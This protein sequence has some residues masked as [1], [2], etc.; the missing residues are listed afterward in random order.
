MKRFSA[1]LTVLALMLCARAETKLFAVGDI[2]P[3]SSLS[4]ATMTLTKGQTV[5]LSTVTCVGHTIDH[6]QWT[7]DIRIDLAGASRPAYTNG[8]VVKAGSEGKF[9]PLNYDPN[10][11]YKVVEGLL[12]GAL[13]AKTTPNAYSV[14]YQLNGGTAGAIHPTEVTYDTMFSVSAPSRVGY[15]FKGWRVV[16]GLN[17]L[18][19]KWGSGNVTNRIDSTSTRCGD[20]MSSAWFL[21]VT[22]EADATVMFAAEW[23][24][25]PCTVTFDANGGSVFPE[26]KQVTYGTTYGSL[27]D[28][29]R[30]GNTFAGWWTTASGGTQVTSATM[31]SAMSAQ[32]LYAHW[33]PN[34]YTLTVDPNGGVYDELEDPRVF[35]PKLRYG[36][37]NWNRIGKATRAGYELKGYYANFNSSLKV[38]DAKG[39]WVEGAYWTID[40]RFCGDHDLQV[41]AQWKGA[42]YVI[43]LDQQGATVVGTTNVMV[44]YLEAMPSVT[45][46]ARTGY[47]FGGYYTDKNGGGWQYYGS[48]GRSARIWDMT[49]GTTLYAKWTP[50]MTRVTFG[51]NGGTGGSSVA[52][53]T[54]DQS[55][56]TINPPSKTGYVFEGYWTTTGA[57]GVQYYNA[58]GTGMRT[59]DRAVDSITLWAKWTVGKYALTLDPNGGRVKDSVDPVELPSKLQYDSQIYK[60]VYVPTRTGYVFAG[61]WTDAENGRRVYDENG[62]NV[63]GAYWTADYVAGGKFSGTTDL[64][65]YAHWTKNVYELA[66]DN[67]FVLER[68]VHAVRSAALGPVAY[69]NES[70]LAVDLSNGSLTILN[71]RDDGEIYTVTP[72]SAPDGVYAFPVEAGKQYECSFQWAGT[73]ASVDMFVF[74][75]K[76]DGSSLGNVH[77]GSTRQGRVSFTVTAPAGA[78]RAQVRF[79]NNTPRSAATFSRVR[80]CPVDP[81][82]SVDCTAV[83]KAFAYDDDL[84]AS[85]GNLAA[86]MREGYEFSG[87]WTASSGGTRVMASSR[88]FPCSTNLWSRWTAKRYWVRFDANEGTTPTS[89]NEVVYASTYGTLP[90]PSRTGYDFAGWWTLPAGGTQVTASTV[91][92]I[93]SSQTLYARWTARTATVSFGKNGGAGGSSGT[94]P[95]YGKA[96]PKIDP[97]V[98]TGYAF[99][100]YWTTV[101]PGGVKYYNEDGSSAKDWDKTSA[102]V[103]LWAKWTARVYEITLRPENGGTGRSGTSK[104]YHRYGSVTNYVYEDCSDLLDDQGAR[105]PECPTR[106]GYAFAGYTNEQGRCMI[107]A[108]GRVADLSAVPDDRTFYGSWT[109]N[110][111]T[112]VFNANGGT[113]SMPVQQAVYDRPFTLPFCTLTRTGYPFRGWATSKDGDVMYADGAVVTNLV[114]EGTC[115]LWARWGEAG[116]YTVVF[117]GNGGSAQGD[118]TET[119][120]KLEYDKMEYL[121]GN[122]FERDGWTFVGWA[123]NEVTAAAGAWVY[124]D[125]ARVSNLTANVEMEVDLYAVWTGL[126][127]RVVFKVGAGPGLIAV[128]DGAHVECH[129]N[130][131]PGSTTEWSSIDTNY[132]GYASKY[133]MSVVV[134]ESWRWPQIVLTDVG[135]RQVFAHKWCFVDTNGEEVVVSENDSAWSI[136]P[137]ESYGMTN[138]VAEWTWQPSENGLAEAVDWPAADFVPFDNADAYGW[139]CWD[140]DENGEKSPR[141]TSGSS[142]RA[143]LAVG[144]PVVVMSTT[145]AGPG[146]LSFD[147]KIEGQAYEGDNPAFATGVALNFLPNAE[148]RGKILRA[149]EEHMFKAGEADGWQTFAWTNEVD[150]PVTVTWSAEG[151][152]LTSASTAWVDHVVWRPAAGAYPD[153]IP[154]DDVTAKAKYDAWKERF[155]ADAESAHKD[156]FLLDCDPAVVETERAKFVITVIEPDGK[157]GWIVKVTSSQKT[158]GE[159]YGNGTI[160]VKGAATLAGPYNLGVEDSSARFFK[161]YLDL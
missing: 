86:P 89:S 156:A 99:D 104:F 10:T 50:N 72:L 101:N 70:S 11:R 153:Y 131:L 95:T 61:W 94:T 145:V 80:V 147:W 106:R 133:V 41:N 79:D 73:A 88:L 43:V 36:T 69:T 47:V 40:G 91:V 63:Q 84:G 78:A 154:V 35:S 74:W 49:T 118:Q 132:V 14:S 15:A 27:P 4:P 115:T 107:D 32:T 37:G 119:R 93:T 42:D 128:D 16:D 146:V 108:S 87:W 140:V 81:Y 55:L 30:A 160:S 19:A 51:K 90:T 136:V 8:Y 123:T 53:P 148:I 38:Y 33:T 56:E 92:A 24:A 97:P 66:Y 157:G 22:A 155:G 143:V 31:V 45:V 127:Y 26:T 158:D 85:F 25:N 113:G 20:G 129:T 142:A 48:D 103:T 62:R 77:E 96:M 67:L 29:I 117:H 126:T 139:Q 18:T 152:A 116:D 23:E 64:V 65:V 114:M 121:A 57:G 59:W 9:I 124:E 12:A 44:T 17:T 6:S 34:E 76:S 109:P 7:F 83:R 105:L 150:G 151:Y 159:A 111:Y 149:D 130:W 75:Q 135:S 71:A 58:D 141:D 98:K 13:I 102:N 5:D 137:P 122:P 112:I 68:W 2:Y 46:P 161:A 134:G 138:L 52:Y 1:V 144:D 39:H 60:S 100:G 82:A 3:D 125:C 110:V 21:N 28:A 120:Q 54:Y